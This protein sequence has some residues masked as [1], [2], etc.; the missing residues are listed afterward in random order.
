MADTAKAVGGGAIGPDVAERSAPSGQDLD[1]RFPGRG[2]WRRDP[3]GS[4]LGV[5]AEADEPGRYRLDQPIALVPSVIYGREVAEDSL[6]REYLAAGMTI[7]EVTRER[8]EAIVR[9]LIEAG[10]LRR[11]QFEAWVDRLLE[12]GRAATEAMVE[13]VRTE[14]SNQL[15]SR[16][17]VSQEDMSRLDA[18]LD[19]L[20]GQLRAAASAPARRAKKT[21]E[22]VKKRAPAKRGRA[23]KTTARKTTARKTTA[24]RPAAR[25][26]AARTTTARKTAPRK[27]AATRR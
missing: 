4:P 2:R 14:V 11:E 24:K 8:A 25:K 26:T 3:S 1:W 7:G 9:D 15:T 20:A 18:R 21:A 5:A 27:A 12:W 13:A 17:L 23:K 19:D 6:M 16:G 10:D 22:T